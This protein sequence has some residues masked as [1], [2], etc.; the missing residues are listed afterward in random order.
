[1]NDKATS[2]SDP[3]ASRAFS[4]IEMLVSISVVSVLLAVLLPGLRGARESADA[5]VCLASQSNIA[6]IHQLYLNDHDGSWPNAFASTGG[7]EWTVGTT[8]TSAYSVLSQVR[9]WV[10][11][12][13][14]AGRVAVDLEYDSLSCPSPLR[15]LQGSLRSNPQIGPMYS[16]G[17]APAFF[18]RAQLWDPDH[19]E[20]RDD[21][22]RWRHRVAASSVAFPSAKVSMFEIADYHGAGDVIGADNAPSTQRSVVAFAD[23]HA[24]RH[25]IAEAS[26][27]LP[28]EWNELYGPTTADRLPYA[29]TV[30][31]FLGRDH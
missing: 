3:R 16:Y 18:T 19:D 10:G 24:A 26:T 1:M 31:G 5:T 20:R 13:H 28:F 27:P 29:T 4:L 15:D 6:R 7:A 12:L 30:H 23:G 11:P 14:Q 21:P 9:G 17:Y 8:F 25:N 22:D 2:G